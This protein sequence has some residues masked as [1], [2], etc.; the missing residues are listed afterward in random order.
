MNG[1]SELVQQNAVSEPEPIQESNLLKNLME[2]PVL[3]NLKKSKSVWTKN[4]QVRNL[5]IRGI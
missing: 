3:A 1:Q 2:E 5:L 4:V